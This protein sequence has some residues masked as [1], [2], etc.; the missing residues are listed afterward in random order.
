MLG[1][2]EKVD[3]RIERDIVGSIAR[4]QVECIDD[5]VDVVGDESL[6]TELRLT[7]ER[8][9][10]DAVDIAVYTFVQRIKQALVVA[11]PPQLAQPPQAPTDGHV[12]EVFRLVRFHPFPYARRLVVRDCRLAPL[13]VALGGVHG[14]LQAPRCGEDHPP[15]LV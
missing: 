13:V 4:K 10:A 3:A 6:R 2:P 11:G 5:F 7:V 12:V 14:A 8:T 9:A 15:N 1:T